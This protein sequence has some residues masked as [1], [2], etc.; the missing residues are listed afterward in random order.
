[1]PVKSVL[2][3]SATS[4]LMTICP[5]GAPL[6]ASAVAIEAAS[7]L[8]TAT[9]GESGPPITGE[10]VEVRA[11]TTQ[12]TTVPMMSPARPREKPLARSPV[13]ISAAKEMQ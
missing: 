5:V 3:D 13:K 12:V 1:M 2:T 9:A 7:T 8:I 10:K 6:A 4:T 11:I